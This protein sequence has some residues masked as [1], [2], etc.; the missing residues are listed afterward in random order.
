M[1]D[2]A[3]RLPGLVVPPLTPFAE[4]LS[5]DY[6]ALRKQVDYVVGECDAAMAMGSVASCATTAPSCG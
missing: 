1:K 5:V 6:D 3:M 4:D 2:K